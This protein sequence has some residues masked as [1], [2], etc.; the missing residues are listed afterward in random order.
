M[1]CGAVLET[2]FT[3]V[4]IVIVAIINEMQSYLR[5]IIVVSKHNF[6]FE[7]NP[8]MNNHPH[9]HLTTIAQSSAQSLNNHCTIILNSR[10][11]KDIAVF[12]KCDRHIHRSGY[13]FAL[14]LKLRI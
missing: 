12:K 6:K 10:T 2:T 4:A 8:F 3:V 1:S 5:F 9:D 13:R 7:Q 11:C 14:Q